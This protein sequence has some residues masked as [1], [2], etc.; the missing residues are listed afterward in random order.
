M[1]EG[2]NIFRL[3]RASFSYLRKVYFLP[4][5]EN[6]F[7]LLFDDYDVYVHVI[8]LI[9]CSQT[10]VLYIIFDRIGYKILHYLLLLSMKWKPF[11]YNSL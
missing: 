3:G 2:S 1:S 4:S 6:F 7:N 9:M 10:Y 5:K 8:A 11:K